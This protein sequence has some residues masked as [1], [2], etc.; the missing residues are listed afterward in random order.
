M[1]LLYFVLERGLEE[2]IS[3]NNYGKNISEIKDFSDVLI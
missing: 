2:K 1:L 3:S